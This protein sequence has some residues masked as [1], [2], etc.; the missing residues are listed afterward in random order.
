MEQIKRLQIKEAEK[1]RTLNPKTIFSKTKSDRK[2]PTRGPK[3]PVRAEKN[4]RAKVSQPAYIKPK[5]KALKPAIVAKPAPVPKP[6]PAPKPTVPKKVTNPKKKSMGT[7]VGP[8][9]PQVNKIEVKPKEQKKLPTVQTT[10]TRQAFQQS[11]VVLPVQVANPRRITVQPASSGVANPRRIT[12]APARSTP[13]SI[14][15]STLPSTPQSTLPPQPE[16]VSKSRV[17]KKKSFFR[18]KKVNPK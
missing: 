2:Q 8:A 9:P 4:P 1:K 17:P 7:R 11:S 13:F 5:Q 18:S 15:Q 6:A 3:K 16:Q 12:V 14:P 10:T